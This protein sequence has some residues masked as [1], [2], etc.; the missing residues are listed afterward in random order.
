M[1][2]YNELMSAITTVISVLVLIGF[3][4]VNYMMTDPKKRNQGRVKQ[5]L[6]FMGLGSAVIVIVSLISLFGPKL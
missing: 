2:N 6:L 4:V 5:I 3:V 1:E